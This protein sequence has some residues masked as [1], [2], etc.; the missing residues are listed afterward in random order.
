MKTLAYLGCAMDGSRK[1]E[2]GNRMNGLSRTQKDE[3]TQFSWD[4]GRT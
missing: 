4:F 2:E 3:Q 1:L